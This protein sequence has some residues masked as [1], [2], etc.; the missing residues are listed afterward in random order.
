MLPRE[1]QCVQLH[2]GQGH[3]LGEVVVR[4]VRDRLVFGQFREGP[5]FAAVAPLFAELREAANEQLFSRVEEL[6]EAIAAL[7]LR[8]Q[9]ADAAPLPAID[10]VQIGEGRI[11]FRLHPGA[12]GEQPSNGAAPTTSADRRREASLPQ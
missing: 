3:L 10:E 2:D 6:D 5:H 8:L 12:G 4:E 1:H 7:G 11:T 9:L